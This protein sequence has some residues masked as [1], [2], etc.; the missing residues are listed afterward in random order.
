MS[1]VVLDQ[2]TYTSKSSHCK[3]LYAWLTPFCFLRYLQS[4]AG[5]PVLCSW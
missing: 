1:F 5:L 2:D 4:M 3:W